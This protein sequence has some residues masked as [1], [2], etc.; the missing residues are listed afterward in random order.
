[1]KSES[2]WRL[3]DESS[4]D[5]ITIGGNDGKE[6][7]FERIAI[8]THNRKDYVIL[9]PVVE[10]YGVKNNEGIVF[11]IDKKKEQVSVVADRQTIANVFEVY[12][13]TLEG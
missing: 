6:Y 13:N 2:F 5:N 4:N 1:M 11:S 3:T 7:H 12:L 8:V 9:R 10:L